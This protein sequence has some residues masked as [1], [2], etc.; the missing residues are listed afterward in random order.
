MTILW[1]R[2]QVSKTSPGRAIT[3][4]S[5]LNILPVKCIETND[6]FSFFTVVDRNVLIDSVNACSEYNIYINIFNNFRAGNLL[7]ICEEITRSDVLPLSGWW[8]SAV[9]FGT[10]HHSHLYMTPDL[11]FVPRLLSQTYYSGVSS[12]CH[13][14]LSGPQNVPNG[15]FRCSM[16]LIWYRP[17]SMFLVLLKW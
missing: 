2:C 10:Q 12:V 7:C 11:C 3:A 4:V 1:E 8:T 5:I 6:C 14:F 13:S 9:N 17:H 16:I 15:V